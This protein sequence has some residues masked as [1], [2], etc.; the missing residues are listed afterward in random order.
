[1]RQT[2]AAPA[3]QGRSTHSR[4]ARR[5]REAPRR[6]LHLGAERRGHSRGAASR[7]ETRVRRREVSMKVM[8]SVRIAGTGMYVPPRVVTNFDLMKQMD[9]SDEWIQR[10]GGIVERPP[11]AAGM[12][13]AELAF[14]AAKVAIQNA[15]IT[16][17]DVDAILVA[18]LSPQHDFPGISCFL[19]NHLGV[20][21]CPAM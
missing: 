4:G 21:G 6:D 10:R 15:G 18:S 7:G 3:Q 16:A 11:V 17:E 1:R 2:R 12:G 5:R 13:P 20:A 9:T 8:R 19:Q 14:E